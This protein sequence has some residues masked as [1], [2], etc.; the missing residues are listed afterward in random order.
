MPNKMLKFIELGSRSPDKRGVETRRQDFDEIYQEFDADRAAEQAARCSQCGVPFC[1]VHCP[2][3]NNIPDWL[4]LAAEGRLEEA[5]EISQATNNFRLGMVPPAQ[6]PGTIR[7]GR[8]PKSSALAAASVEIGRR[9]IP[10]RTATRRRNAC[11][12]HPASA[13]YDTRNGRGQI[14]LDPVQ[15]ISE[16]LIVVITLRVM[17]C[18]SVHC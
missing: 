15:A 10:R 18:P 1:Q 2:V 5:Y 11:G 8:L 6:V 4:L 12:L 3:H 7:L 16:N 13:R 9:P 17:G 14:R